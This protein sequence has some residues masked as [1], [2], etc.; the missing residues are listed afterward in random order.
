MLGL[1]ARI[2]FA[3]RCFFTL[4]FQ[5]R[6]PDDVLDHF[7]PAA[8]PAGVPSAA[9]RDDAG[10][11]AVQLL[12]ILQRDGRLVDF[13]QEDIGS[14]ADAQ[15]GAAVRDV[16]AN[17]RTSLARYVTLEPVVGDPEGERIRLNGTVDPTRY[18]LVG[19]VG[20]Q[21]SVSGVVRH[22]GWRVTHLSLPPLPGDARD[23]VAPAEVEVM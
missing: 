8:A 16:H 5:G 18:K 19:N 20:H 21:S 23:V 2:A 15:I 14:Y 9:P 13:L 3:F 4:L 11:R 1:G 17:C 6:L 12:G 22:R 10:D 7:R